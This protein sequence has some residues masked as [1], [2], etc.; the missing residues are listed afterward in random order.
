MS[1]PL[2][3]LTPTLPVLDA[4]AL[5]RLTELA[6]GDAAFL[7]DLVDGYLQ[8][9][10]VRLVELRRQALA[11]DAQA[12]VAAAHALKGASR[13]IGAQRVGAFA[14]AIESAGRDGQLPSPDVLDALDHEVATAAGALGTFVTQAGT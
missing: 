8:E 11:R 13:T 5:A 9:T 1:A 3:P 7:A 2:A 14:Y 10:P 6:E 12:V 4:L